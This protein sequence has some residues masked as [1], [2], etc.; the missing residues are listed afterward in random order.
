MQTLKT[1]LISKRDS[2]LSYVL[3]RKGLDEKL[4]DVGED[5]PLYDLQ[6]VTFSKIKVGTILVWRHNLPVIR[7]H[8]KIETKKGRPVLDTG[9]IHRHYHFGIVE[10]IEKKGDSTYITFSELLLDTKFALPY[11]ELGVLVYVKNKY[12][13]GYAKNDGEF[14]DAPDLILEENPNFILRK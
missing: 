8:T 12:E 9:P 13:N 14:I 7:R 2:C 11:L 4:Y 6:R 3:R 1:L 10:C 5:I